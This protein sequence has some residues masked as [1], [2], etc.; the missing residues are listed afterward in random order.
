MERYNAAPHASQRHRA[1]QSSKKRTSQ[2][3]A[4]VAVHRLLVLLVG[5]S[6]GAVALVHRQKDGQRLEELVKVDLNAADEVVAL[7]RAGGAKGCS[8]AVSAG[9]RAWQA[10]WR[11]VSGGRGRGTGKTGLLRQKRANV[12][13]VEDFNARSI[14]S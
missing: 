8:A 14:V 4:A 7:G 3:V 2:F 1:K 6:C 13:S 11:R 10:R 5:H 9:R 12:L